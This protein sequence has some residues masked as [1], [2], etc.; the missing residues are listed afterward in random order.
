MV[1]PEMQHTMLALF[2]I[3]SFVIATI[4]LFS[5]DEAHRG[6]GRIVLGLGIVF[7]GWFMIVQS[8]HPVVLPLY[9]V[10]LAFSIPVC[11]VITALLGWRKY[12]RAFPSDPSTVVDL[13][14]GEE[15][16]RTTS[17]NAQ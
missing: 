1:T 15:K 13:A 2:T 10:K 16:V 6:S 11:G 12:N 7:A 3:I 5:K 17:I 14:T 9:L 4:T 8:L